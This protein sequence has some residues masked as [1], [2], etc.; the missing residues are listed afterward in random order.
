MKEAIKKEK[1]LLTLSKQDTITLTIG[2]LG[3]FLGRVAIFSHLNPVAIAFLASY[4]LRGYRIYLLA[5]FMAIGVATRFNG[6]YLVKYTFAIAMVLASHF[7]INQERWN[8]RVTKQIKA[9]VAAGSVLIPGLVMTFFMGQNAIQFYYIGMTFLESAL[10]FG[11]VFLMESGIRVL[12]GKDRALDSESLL[13]TAILLGMV[14]AGVSDIY[15]AGL[16]IKHFVSAVVVL[17]IAQKGDSTTATTAGVIMGLIIAMTTGTSPSFIAVLAVSGM[18]AG[19]GKHTW[20]TVL[21]FGSGWVIMSLFLDLTKLNWGWLVSYGL[22]SAVIAFGPTTPLSLAKT[23]TFNPMHLEKTKEYTATRLALISKSFNKLAETLGTVQKKYILS[24]KEISDIIDNVANT[25]CIHCTKRDSCWGSNFQQTYQTFK[26]MAESCEKQ[27]PLDKAPD[28]L[29]SF[30]VQPHMLLTNINHTYGF[31]KNNLHWQNRTKEAK[32]IVAWQLKQIG[33]V[34]SHVSTDVEN[35]IR[36]APYLEEAIQSGFERKKVE[37]DHVIVLEN[38]HGQYSVEIKY[39]GPR[40]FLSGAN[41]MISGIIGRDMVE[42]EHPSH[43]RRQRMTYVEEQKFR[44]STG[45]SKLSKEDSQSGDSHGIMHVS[46]SKA[47]VLLS[48]GMG[49][50]DRASEESAATVEMFE[51]FMETGFDKE[52]AVKII[53]SIMVLK[54]EEDY[55]STLDACLVDLYSGMTDFVKMGASATYLIYP[56]EVEMIKNSTLPMGILNDIK[57]GPIKKQ[58][59]AGDIIVMVTDGVTEPGNINKEEELLALLKNTALRDPQDLA[60]YILNEV[61]GKSTDIKDDMTVLVAKI[62]DR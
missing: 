50:G 62:L 47:L 46:G 9:I 19:L 8:I 11:L 37:I 23:T 55:F 42:S 51:D 15:I 35:E 25:T 33:T 27:G 34:I 24:Q 17:I 48:D 43:R 41:D 7:F 45:L 32:E 18:I 56:N 16:S 12:E 4:I 21:G 28:P 39:K 53:N 2:F 59:K 58:L 61:K 29:T 5:L 40:K 36:F 44:V 52:T 10:A 54:S 38:Q 26:Q 31:H 22:A 49:S 20:Q 14:V 3:L 6:P 30:C 60:D 57:V 13:S 1:H